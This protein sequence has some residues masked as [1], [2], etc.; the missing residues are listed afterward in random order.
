MD[1]FIDAVIKNNV[2]E[3]QVFL[4]QNDSLVNACQD[5]AKITPLHFAAQNNAF[6]CAQALINAGANIHAKTVDGLTPLDIAA[7][8]QNHDIVQ[9]FE[10]HLSE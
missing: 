7:L 2:V 3:V 6:D 5:D 4:S 9:L 10:Q 1:Q 8:H